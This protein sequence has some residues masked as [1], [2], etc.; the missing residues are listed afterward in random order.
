MSAGLPTPRCAPVTLTLAAL[1]LAAVGA[2]TRAAAIGALE[3]EHAFDATIAAAIA[4][5]RHIY[6]VPA[7]L[8]R[9]VMRQESGFSPAAR[10]R[11]GAV[12]LMQVMP[13][14]AEALGVR[15][16]ELKDPGKNVLAGARMLA[17][18]LAHYKGDVISALVAYNARP[19]KL[20]APLPRNGETPEYVHAVLSFWRYYA[21]QSGQ[22]L[23]Q[24]D[25]TPAPSRTT[26]RPPLRPSRRVD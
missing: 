4:E 20:G 7:D 26:D 25:Q 6:P 22:D 21:R 8:V 15:V 5:T 12:G 16:D 23:P 13:F 2:P 10:S 3:N 14:N 9:A 19:R 17:V 18:L 11:A 1:T 24:P